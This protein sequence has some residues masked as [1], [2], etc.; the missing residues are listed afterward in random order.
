MKQ[1]VFG[2][3][4]LMNPESARK[5]LKRRVEARP[6]TLL[7]YMRKC[8]APVNG[9][10]YM[11][12]I[13]WVGGRVG[14]VLLLVSW[15]ELAMLKVREVGYECVDV[16]RCIAGPC[17]GATF[18]FIAPDR[19]LPKLKILKSYLDTCLEGV[20][21]TERTRWLQETIV[22]NEI[23][24]DSEAPRYVNAIPIKK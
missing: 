5:T 15:R 7:G 10:L 12:L 8:N 20:P 2:Y 16:T 23:E 14:G 1:Y 22:V 4:S 3:G 21:L 6:A 13:P 18:A 9:Y 24:D 17:V 19:T 11:N